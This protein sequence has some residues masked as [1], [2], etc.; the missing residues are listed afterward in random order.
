MPKKEQK[1]GL[2]RDLKQF[3]EQATTDVEEMIA[4][5]V[6]AK[7]LRT[8]LET[9][10]LGVEEWLDDAIRRLNRAID[11]RTFD[12]RELRKKQIKAELSQLETASQR[13]ARLE[14]ELTTLG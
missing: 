11:E 7:A 8:E 14:A 9:R 13:R 1:M 5:V 6:Q 10:A 4:L 12:R 3:N 2:I